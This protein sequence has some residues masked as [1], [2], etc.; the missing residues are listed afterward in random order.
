LEYQLLQNLLSQVQK[1]DASGTILINDDIAGTQGKIY[2]LK[3]LVNG[4]YN[5]AVSNTLRTI[6]STVAISGNNV[7]VIGASTTYKPIINIAAEYFDVNALTQGRAVTVTI[8]DAAGVVFTQAYKNSATVGK[9]FVTTDLPAGQYT[10]M[11][12]KGNDS[13]IKTI[14]K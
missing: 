3:A 14:S 11:V 8:L 12:T 2:N 7:S 9:R 4:T 5:V 1:T 10:V 6:N 13:I